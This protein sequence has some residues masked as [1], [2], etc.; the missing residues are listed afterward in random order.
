MK[1]TRSLPADNTDS[2]SYKVGKNITFQGCAIVPRQQ[3]SR[4]DRIVDGNCSE[5]V[6]NQ[7]CITQECHRGLFGQ[8]SSKRNHNYIII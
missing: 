3:K 1:T 7:F 5:N 2:D 8:H 4:L 6:L